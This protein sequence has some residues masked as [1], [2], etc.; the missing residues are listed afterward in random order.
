V[1][2]LRPAGEV[3][4]ADETLQQVFG[5]ISESTQKSWVVRDSRGV[6]GLVK[7]TSLKRAAEE[8]VATT[9]VGDLVKG[10]RYPHLHTDHS[11]DDALERMGAEGVDVLPVVS[12]ADVRQLLGVVRLQDV[13]ELYGIT[14]KAES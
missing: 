6:V 3:L 11:L 10:T 14:R 5:R 12:R 9:T 7:Q 4:R 1:Q 2:V 13:L 8:M